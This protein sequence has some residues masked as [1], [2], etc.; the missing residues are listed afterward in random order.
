MHKIT[1]AFF[2]LAIA[3]M[4]FNMCSSFVV[5]DMIVYTAPGNTLA[6]SLRWKRPVVV[7]SPVMRFDPHIYMRYARGHIHYLI[8]DANNV[9][10]LSEYVE[11]GRKAKV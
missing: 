1:S 9:A 2:T 11:N 10:G 6:Q 7:V 4:D 5:D 8:E 3:H